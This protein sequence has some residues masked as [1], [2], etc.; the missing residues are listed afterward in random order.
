[1]PEMELYMLHAQIKFAVVVCPFVSSPVCFCL[2]RTASQHITV[3]LYRPSVDRF[4]GTTVL[5]YYIS[6][7]TLSLREIHSREALLFHCISSIFFLCSCYYF[8]SEWN[9][10]L[11]ALA[12]SLSAN[13]SKR[14]V[15][16]LYWRTQ[17]RRVGRIE[18]SEKLPE[19]TSVTGGQSGRDTR[20]N[21]LWRK[22]WRTGPSCS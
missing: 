18:I 21:R 8:L 2:N 6:I 5:N 13:V 22:R 16:Y 14:V 4:S 10:G 11:R 1:M 7:C 3:H 19:R 17:Q 15:L 12:F 20:I 9:M